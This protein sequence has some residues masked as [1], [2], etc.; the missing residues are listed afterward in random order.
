M[1]REFLETIIV[2]VI[3]AG[4]LLPVRILFVSY[5][6]DH[7]IG[8]LGMVTLI[9]VVILY[10]AK[11]NK[12]GWFGNAFVKQIFKI[13]TGKRKYLFIT[14]A[15]FFLIYFG[16]II[17][18]VDAS[19]TYLLEQKLEIKSL[20]GLDTFEDIPFEP[21]TLDDLG[22]V[23]LVFFTRFDVLAISIG[24]VNDISHGYL[25]H[26]AIV[27]VAEELELIGIFIYMTHSIKKPQLPKP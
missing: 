8:S 17:L 5:V 10:L 18:G 16:I 21:L 23:W 6:N 12:L 22:K 19:N 7:W 25:L 3:L 20:S 13:K 11:K 14:G 26:F 9:S 15:I 27:F 1:T 24:I 4:I 2:G